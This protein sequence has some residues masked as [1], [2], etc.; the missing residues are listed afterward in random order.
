MNSPFIKNTIIIGEH[1][2]K[3]ILEEKK[4]VEEKW[5]SKSDKLRI[6]FCGTYPK[7]SNGYAKVCY[8]IS[9]W[10][11]TYKDISWNVWGFQNYGQVHSGNA[12]R[13]EIPETVDIIDALKMEKDAGIQ[14]NGFGERLIGKY[15]KENPYDVII[16]FNDSMITSA[17]TAA[18]I[19]D[20]KDFR[21]KFKLVSYMDQVFMYQKP[22]YIKL[23]NQH[24]D[25]I[26]AFTEF[27]KKM[28]YQIG[29]KKEMPIYVFNHGFDDKLYFPIPKR[30]ARY[31][32]D[33]PQDAFIVQTLN[34]NQPRKNFDCAIIAWAGFVKR[35]YIANNEKRDEYDFKINKHCKRPI[36]FAIGTAKEGY[37][38]L[39]QILEHECKLID[40]DFEYAKK[41]LWF[42]DSP[43]QLADRDINIFMNCADAT[44]CPVRGGGWEF[45]AFEG[46]GVS[47]ASISSYVGGHKEFINDNNA[48]V[49]KPV[50]KQYGE[51]S[52]KMKGIGNLDE[53][54]SSEDFTDGLWKYFSNPELCEK[55]GRNG[56]KQILDK[57]R[58]PDVV[59]RFKRS[60]IDDMIAARKK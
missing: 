6:L 3:E 44:F 48:I 52:S 50:C 21:H 42:I 34:R 32:Y 41:T 2:I 16:I 57:Y 7:A 58:W 8:Y 17:L 31:Y 28:A 26:I 14:G 18:I 53:L 5:N 56:R 19:N 20:M 29:I 35:H 12:I 25:Y 30:L 47:T 23:L 37:W 1:S 13:N 39:E 27:W 40:L 24:Y 15:L 51:L 33:L 60:F 4:Q 43:Q 46:M 49:V 54:C 10:L 36:L 9:K 55:H 59:D 22:D 11:G 45:C 38:D